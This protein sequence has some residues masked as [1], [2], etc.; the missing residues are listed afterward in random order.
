[1]LGK[2]AQYQLPSE[3]EWEWAC[4]AGT[5]GKFSCPDGELAQY[6]WYENNTDEARPVRKLKP[7][8]FG[9]FDMHGNAAEWCRDNFLNAGSSDPLTKGYLHG[10]NWK[11]TAR[12]CAS[13]ARDPLA[14]DSQHAENGFRIMKTH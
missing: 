1:L 9:L 6:C 10:G 7:N 5:V 12:H 13:S 4:R 2:N 14:V 3:S 8:P 11:R